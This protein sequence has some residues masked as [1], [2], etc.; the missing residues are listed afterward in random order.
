MLSEYL[1]FIP[2]I[3]FFGLSGILM[4][5]F[6]VG[7]LAGYIYNVIKGI[8]SPLGVSDRKSYG[9]SSSGDPI[10][11]LTGKMGYGNAIKGPTISEKDIRTAITNLSNMK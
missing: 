4:L 3:F 11:E 1:I 2:I 10:R 9:S 8:Y 7:E 6:S 5:V